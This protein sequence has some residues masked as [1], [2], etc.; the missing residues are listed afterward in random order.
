MTLV[1]FLYMH[2]GDLNKNGP[3]RLIYLNDWSQGV[4]LLEKIRRYSFVEGSVLL[5]MDF[6]LSKAHAKHRV[7]LFLLPAVRV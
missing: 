5:G 4:S 1:W 7:S 6:E 3:H 2:C